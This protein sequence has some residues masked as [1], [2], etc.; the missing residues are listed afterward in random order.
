MLSH[1][2]GNIFC[3]ERIESEEF[4]KIEDQLKLVASEQKTDLNE[5]LIQKLNVNTASTCVKTDHD[6]LRVCYEVDQNSV[7]ARYRLKALDKIIKDYDGSTDYEISQI[8]LDLVGDAL[9]MGA[10]LLRSKNM[11]TNEE[12]ERYFVSGT[13][14]HL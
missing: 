6:L 10:N 11:F 14:F 9:R 5:Y 4:E 12:Y 2:Y 8:I 13:E 3:P 7:P 1:K